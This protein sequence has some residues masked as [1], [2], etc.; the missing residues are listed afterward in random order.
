M[1][2]NPNLHMRSYKDEDDYW[3]IRAFLRETFLLNHRREFNW[4][5]ARLDYWRWHLLLNCQEVGSL[6]GLIYIW[7]ADAGQIDF[8][9]RFALFYPE[10]R[11]FFIE[12]HDNFNFA[13]VSTNDP[14]GSV[15]HTRN[16]VNPIT[17]IKLTGKLN[18]K[19]TIASIYA[20]DELPDD[21]NDDYAHFAI[22]RIK[23]ALRGDS[24]LGGIY[25]GRERR[26]GYNRVA[27]FD[28]QFRPTKSSS[29]TSYTLFSKTDD[30]IDP[31]KKP[32]SS[33]CR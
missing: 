8:N 33:H 30:K 17:G 26:N 4:P 29:I 18:Q 25:T 5:V 23:R 24:Y 6:E 22:T 32:G 3:R 21:A 9:Q 19:T 31:D 1:T 28:G 27:G 15:V 11:P 12:G 20:L 10:R 13:C 2:Q 7:E 14:V 16:I